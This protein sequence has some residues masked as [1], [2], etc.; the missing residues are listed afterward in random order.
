MKFEY[1]PLFKQERDQTRYV[2][3]TSNYVQE[4]KFR[5][6]KFLEVQA[7]ALRLLARQAFFL[8]N[9]YFRTS[10]LENLASILDDPEA[11]D[12]D[13]FVAAALL[14]NAV[15]SAEG[16][17][18]LCQ[19]TGT[20][21][22][23]GYKGERVLTGVDDARYLSRGVFEAY[24]TFN[25]RASQNAPLSIL[26]EKNTG[27]NLPAQIEIF[28]TPGS[29]YRFYFVAKG[30]GSSNKTALYQENKS[31]LR[32]ETTLLDFL[33]EKI[34]AIGVAACPPYRL[35]VVIGGLSPEM[36]TK[37]VKL[38]SAGFLDNLV[39]RPTGRPHG[40]R[41]REWEKKVLQIARETGLGA[42]FGGVAL[43][44]EA[45]V[46]RLPRHGGSLPVGIGLSCNADRNLIAKINRHG[47]FV[48]A[49]DRNPARF[50]KKI[51]RLKLEEAP[52]INLDEP[53][54]SLAEELSRYPV[55]TRLRLSGTL[56]V[57]RDMAHLR[58]KK[59]LDS[60]QP[61]PE[62]FKKHPVY[63][64]GPA[65]APR[66]WPTGSF[67]PTTA[68]RMDSYV[69]EFMKS[70]A[71]RVM[72]AKGNRSDRVIEACRRYNGFYLG[73]IGGAAAL[74]AREYIIS[75]E[76]IDFEDLGMEAVRKIVV[77]NLPAFI[78]YDNRGHKLY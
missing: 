60:G 70:G 17:L 52:A 72:L 19:D 2:K 14:R 10:H 3:L 21:N 44:V 20:A 1:T 26:E 63:Y 23:I 48:E 33:R 77:Q 24:T 45:R 54:D 43:A 11:S 13:R 62:Y 46:I 28:S 36:T 8:V 78:I 9:F 22:I 31:L 75:S 66:S 25:L 51:D 35:A 73:T 58:L 59:M 49:M 6:R 18:P 56:I 57:A 42:Q 65:K 29:E 68:Q 39:T 41:D 76:V 64:A 30:G 34:R 71:S 7:E 74:V 40:Y 37:T 27:N 32:D 47:I 61:L 53:V 50:L 67:G 38:A 15:I 5:G 4:I 16:L 69:E 55:G 12:N